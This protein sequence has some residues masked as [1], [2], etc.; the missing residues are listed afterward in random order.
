MSGAGAVVEAARK[1]EREADGS[2][3]DSPDRRVP[4][5]DDGAD[6][7]VRLNKLMEEIDSVEG[8]VDGI[9]VKV[10]SAVKEAIEAKEGVKKVVATVASIQSDV[11]NMKK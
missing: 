2:H 10:D 7:P 9:T 11:G 8:K 1:L 6:D 4:R 3:P 5:Q